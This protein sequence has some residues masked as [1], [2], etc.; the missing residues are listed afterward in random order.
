MFIEQNLDNKKIG[1]W[2]KFD[3]ILIFKDKLEKEI[4]EEGQKC[5]MFLI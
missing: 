4:E 2:F 3:G 5:L 1:F